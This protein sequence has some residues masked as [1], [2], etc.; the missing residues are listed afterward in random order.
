MKT[1]YNRARICCRGVLIVA[2]LLG[3][4][5]PV[6]NELSEAV[7]LGTQEQEALSGVALGIATGDI[8]TGVIH[9]LEFHAEQVAGE[10]SNMGA[11]WIRINADVATTS[12]IIYR[13]IIEKAHAKN[14]LVLV[15]VPAKYCGSDSNQ[16]EIDGFTTAYVSH[17]NDLVLNVFNGTGNADAFEIGHEPNV[18][19]STG[20][21][22]TTLRPRVSP[23][24]FAWLL[25]RVWQWKQA[26]GRPELI[27]SGGIKN[28]YVSNPS[29]SGQPNPDDP[30]WNALFASPAFIVSSGP[31]VVRMRPF[32]Y[33]GV[34][35]Y[36]DRNMDYQC[37]NAGYTTCFTVWK[38]KVKSGLQAAAARLNTATGTTNTR[39]F[40]TE[41]GFQLAP[42]VDCLPADNCCTGIEN[43][44][45]TNSQPYN[46][47]PPTPPYQQM[48][49]AMN[50]AG[51]TFA[52]SGVTPV[53]I[54]ASY[55]DM[56]PKSF[57]LRGVWDPELNKYR[58]KTAA[59]N[60]F[61][62]LAGGTGSTN[63][64]ACWIT[65]SFFPVDFE[66]GDDLRTTSSDDWA[67]ANF[68][69]VCAPGER[70]MG[71]SKSIAN[72]W[73]RLGMCYKDPLDSGRYNH[74]V[75]ETNPPP[76][77]PDAPRC[78]VRDV[79]AG[80]DRGTSVNPPKPP[81]TSLDWDAG[82]WRAEC[83]PDEYVAGVAQGLDHH[84]SRILCCPQ[85]LS[86][87][88]RT[89]EAVVFGTADNRQTTDSGDWDSAG[90]KGECGVGRYV[91][92]VS[93]TPAGQPNALLC[94][95]Q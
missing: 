57:G 44:T 85:T 21:S 38:A 45:L 84:F 83:G 13:R 47:T 39:L 10:F 87:A 54:W 80:D 88:Q 53:A 32:D 51:D 64:E 19:E 67:Y 18:S 95:T 22:D 89:C 4:C 52:A 65:G 61:R 29:Y 1:E 82:N 16:T 81:T 40:A 59:W 17:L 41:F 93:R 74:P 48:A 75:P 37:I 20:C 50:A 7:E 25:R 91:A 92:G 90:F 35:P 76:T 70:I 77:T 23:N 30:Y 73:A 12:P 28:V 11:Q 78:T 68:K 60:K 94:C 46:M 62:S 3:A 9:S 69:G 56:W 72:G 27:V 14:I 31:P 66:N 79:Q 26:N 86:A 55:R 36:N 5:G 8:H 42:Q 2:A 33:F 63:P 15:V 71:L 6:E 34:H 49:A 24:A 58:V 43:C